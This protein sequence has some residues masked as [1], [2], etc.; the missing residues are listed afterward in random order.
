MCESCGHVDTEFLFFAP[1]D[2]RDSDH[3]KKTAVPDSMGATKPWIRISERQFSVEETLVRAN[4]SFGN[5]IALKH[6]VDR[7]FE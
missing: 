2:V 7:T 5:L 6:K 3:L 4:N 1:H